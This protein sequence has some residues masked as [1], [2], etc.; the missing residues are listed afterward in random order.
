M[1]LV[2]DEELYHFSDFFSEATLF[3]NGTEWVVAIT[4]RL[5]FNVALKVVC[6][7]EFCKTCN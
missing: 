4:L 2:F 3:I 7:K 6:L 1:I 5:S